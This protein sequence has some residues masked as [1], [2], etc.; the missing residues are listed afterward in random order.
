MRTDSTSRPN[1]TNKIITATLQLNPVEERR[2]ACFNEA[3]GSMLENLKEFFP[4]DHP[5]QKLPSFT[6]RA[7]KMH[8]NHGNKGTISTPNGDRT[9][10]LSGPGLQGDSRIV[11]LH[12]P[13]GA[14]VWKK[15]LGEKGTYNSNGVEIPFTV[16]KIEEPKAATEFLRNSPP[17]LV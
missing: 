15:Q 6:P 7:Q 12:E 2:I 9:F 13:L 11:S 17:S 16:T 3:K 10:V 5:A 1:A 4:S 14:A 8:F